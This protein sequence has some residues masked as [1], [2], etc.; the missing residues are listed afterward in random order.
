MKSSGDFEGVAG[1][2][3]AP[4]HGSRIPVYARIADAVLDFGNATYIRNDDGILLELKQYVD[5]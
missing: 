3:G 5:G 4:T 2:R 1:Q